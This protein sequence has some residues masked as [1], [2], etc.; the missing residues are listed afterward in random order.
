MHPRNASSPPRTRT[1]PLRTE[2]SFDSTRSINT[3]P[4]PLSS[5]FDDLS[6][7]PII[8]HSRQSAGGGLGESPFF[9][10]SEDLRQFSA[11]TQHGSDHISIGSTDSEPILSTS[12]ISKNLFAPDQPSFSG[13][14]HTREDRLRTLRQDAMNNFLPGTASF[15]GEKLMV[16]TDTMNDIYY[17][18]LS[19]YQQ[20]QYER[21]LEI[22][23][24][25][26]TLNKSV[27]CR[28]LAAL[29]SLA[30]ENG[31]DALDYLGHGNPFSQKKDI[32]QDD[33]MEGCI[34]LE[35]VMCFARGKAYLLIKDIDKA[36]E[37]FKEALTVDVKCYDALEALVK[38]NMMEEKAE[39]EFV[40]TLPYEEH[41]GAD[42]DYFRYLYGLKLKKD[43]LNGKRMDPDSDN[44]A[45]SL[46]VQLSIAE[47]YFSQSRYEDCLEICKEIKVQDAFFTESIPLHLSCLYELGMK[48]ELYEYAQELVDRLNDEAVAWHAVGLYYLY[49]KK[50]LEARR[51]FSQALTINRFFQQSWLGYGH[52]F[53]LEK[54]HDQAI[55]A[56]MA[57]SRLIPGSHLPYMNIA[58]QYMEQ[59]KMNLAFEYF[60]KSL[61][62]CN[63]D[64][65][66][67][68]ELAVYYYKQGLYKDALEHLHTALSFAK[69]RQCQR[70]PIW[71]KIWCN[72]GHVYRHPPFQNYD[73]ALR[74][75][76]NALARNPKNADARAA[77][78][79]IYQLK[80]NTA[81]AIAEYHEALNNTD[82]S[83]L[84]NELLET[85]LLINFST[86]YASNP[87]QPC[88]DDTFDI[89]QMA[90][91]IRDAQDEVDIELKENGWIIDRTED[92]NES[93]I[94]DQSALVTEDD[95]I[96]DEGDLRPNMSREWL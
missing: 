96:I 54:D 89:F 51:Y 88:M 15:I 61:H 23:N 32:I 91:S 63:H 82:A 29:C 90:D 31:I 94:L 58:M 65:F 53:S 33:T 52:S 69:K 30:L 37:C 74:C 72:L 9:D 71:E 5:E 21:A 19:Y 16:S 2:S 42:S 18:A 25:K 20:Q 17:I 12:G 41:C 79:M 67:F 45:K 22:L 36:R 50:N 80:G 78:G 7:S 55:D 48:N 44:I 64:P 38:Y 11:T 40:M 43:I 13:K 49:I 6:S 87:N 73:R 83:E 47:G 85:A 24:K 28:Y 56:Y 66:L 27:Q 4:R 68:N 57:C 46:D 86:S 34:K 92:S 75:F 14:H 39:W 8:F 10:R 26:Q 62:K 81:R 60:S 3:P 93:T 35:S 77:V 1:T 95:L 84:V 76:E 70:S 59:N